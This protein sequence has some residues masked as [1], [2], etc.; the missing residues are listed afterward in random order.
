MRRRRLGQDGQA[1]V[2]FAIT[3]PI[4]LA[5]IMAILQLALMYNAKT[6]CNYA[7]FVGARSGVVFLPRHDWNPILPLPTFGNANQVNW[8]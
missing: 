1:M 7:A 5:V 6:M 4:L 8:W 2:E 3:F